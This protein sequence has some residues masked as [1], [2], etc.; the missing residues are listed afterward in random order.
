MN[1]ATYRSITL[2]RNWDS[3]SAVRSRPY[4]YQFTQE[5]FAQTEPS[6]WFPAALSSALTHDSVKSLPKKELLLV[7]AHHLVHFMDYTTTLEMAHVNEAVRCIVAGNLNKYFENE[8]HHVALKLYADEAYHALFSKDIA[9]QVA[10][11]FNLMRTKSTRI[12]G[13]DFILE[14]SPPDLKC[15]TRFCIGFASETLI[16]RELLKLS[17][18]ALVAPVTNM[19]R[20][21]L[22]DEGRHAIFFSE[23]FSQLWRQ[24]SKIERDY[25][26]KILPKVL[27][28]FCQPDLPFLRMV[29]KTR[30][31]LGDEV[32][33]FALANQA[34]RMMEICK[35]TLLAIQRTDLLDDESYFVHFQSAG[36]VA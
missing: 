19:L 16:T 5:D 25:V 29:F 24:I 36:L 28:A 10:K 1:E 17:T 14:Q 7:H 2:F 26:A 18:G 30:P 34:V 32:S 35:P 3:S 20:D 33:A 9:D 4:A 23:C 31:A 27:A 11:H 12:E 13:L 8:E 6:L 21:H 15:L 22:Y